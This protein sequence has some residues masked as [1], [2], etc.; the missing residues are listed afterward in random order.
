LV[1]GFFAG[2]GIGNLQKRNP[3]QYYPGF[4]EQNDAELRKRSEAILDEL[5]NTGALELFYEDALTFSI[6]ERVPRLSLIE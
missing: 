3:G 1:G 2:E 5:S 6:A 4:D